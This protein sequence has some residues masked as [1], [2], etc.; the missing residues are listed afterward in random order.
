[1]AENDT[2]RNADFVG[3]VVGDAKNPP[4]TR[5]LTGWFG[6][7]G[8]ERYRRLYT[9]AQLSGYVDIPADA[10]LHTEEIRDAQ[11]AGS[12]LVW[13]KADAPLKSG[14][15]TSS[16][17][18]RF[19]Q[20]HVAQ[21]FASGGLSLEQAGLR[22]ATQSPGCE[23]T[24]F[25]GQCTK[26]PDVGGCWP[27][28][29]AAPHCV[30]V[31]GFT[32]KCTHQP[33]PN[34]TQ[35]LGCTVY[36][37]PTQDLTHNPHICNIV[38]TGLPGCGGF[39]PPEKGGEEKAGAQAEA[40]VVA[41][42]SLLGCGYTKTWGLCHTQLLGCPQTKDCPT[43][44][45]GCGWSK[46]PICTDLPGCGWTKQPALCQ[47]TV[48]QGQ[49]P[50]GPP[51][52]NP[53][54]ARQ[55]QNFAGV[56]AGGAAANAALQPSVICATNIACNV[57]IFCPTRILQHCRPQTIFEPHCW[58][59]PSPF[60]PVTPG[61]P[62]GPRGGGDTPIMRGGGGGGGFAAF[63]AAANQGPII[64]DTQINICNPSAIDLC[65]T[66]GCNTQP[67]TALCTVVAPGCTQFGP[68]C[69]TPD[70]VCTQF[71]PQCPTSCGP[72]CQTQQIDCT[73]V[74]EICLT[75]PVDCTQF[76]PKCPPSQ[77]GVPCPTPAGPICPTAESCAPNCTVT[78][79]PCFAP[80]PPG[81]GAV[82]AA[83]LQGGRFG[84]FIPVCGPT[85]ATHC[86]YCPPASFD[87]TCQWAAG[88]QPQQAFAA[89]QAQVGTQLIQCN[90]SAIDA[91]PTRIGC[92]ATNYH[93]Q[94]P[95]TANP[96]CAQ[97]DA[98]QQGA[99]VGAAQTAGG[100]VHITLLTFPVW[101]CWTISPL[102]WH[103]PPHSPLPWLCPPSPL[104]PPITQIW[105]C[106]G[107]PSA[108]DACPTRRCPQ[109]GGGLG[110]DPLAAFGAAQPA[111]AQLQN[112]PQTPLCPQPSPIL[113]CPP[114]PL[115]IQCHASLA[116]AC[117]PSLIQPHCGLQSAWCPPTPAC[118]SQQFICPSKLAC[119]SLVP[120]QCQIGTAF[121]QTEACGI[122]QFCGPQGGGL[123]GD[124]L[125]GGAAQ[126]QAA[127]AIHPTI[128][129]QL[130]PQCPPSQLLG[131][132][133]FPNGD[134][135]FF[136]GCGPHSLATVCTQIWSCGGSAV[137]LCPSR[138]CGGGGIEQAQFGAAAG[139]GFPFPTGFECGATAF[140]GCLQSR[141]YPCFTRPPRCLIA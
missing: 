19:L 48:S 41:T 131:C 83:A 6:D 59:I 137:D 22:C 118:P 92:P 96:T 55:P 88:P 94:C 40:A 13:V 47:Q 141:F 61:C 10:I 127:A 128:W 14:G 90:P 34:P 105:V 28:I 64:P 23:P 132:R 103:C 7:S 86:F 93:Q 35:Y 122:S 63:G 85:P 139:R 16:R 87:P 129:T 44:L 52:I 78:P 36:H 54:A 133:T 111:G 45:P 91:C 115:I 80:Q 112:I 107:G 126:P 89:R 138:I 70:S 8:E 108:V 20:G 30:E 51:N 38:A 110:G 49:V 5:L 69:P 57:T 104:C 50:C 68:P 95:I 60:C 76:G 113:H 12:V 100:G 82:G 125:A 119:P 25:T 109:G 37:C 1:M 99:Q 4:E 140:L 32:G 31:T 29:T 24:G 81:G 21:D 18:A 11:P 15:P 43:A 114:S 124:P 3:R 73:K 26:E 134:C 116:I 9:D 53:E 120:Q 17:A 46:N 136:G 75:H 135:T 102:P 27:C 56:G 97:L 72:A 67:P 65:P 66:H 74:G 106:G 98:A 33:W 71:G 84:T 121:C 42:T 101:Q 123:G 79:P 117:P 2:P 58:P 39:N 77:F 62:F 130:G